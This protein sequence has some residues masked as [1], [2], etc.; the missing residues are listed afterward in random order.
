MFYLGKFSELSVKALDPQSEILL[1]KSPPAAL[2]AAV[3]FFFIL[4]L[5][6]KLKRL[7][8]ESPH[9]IWCKGFLGAERE[10]FEP[11]EV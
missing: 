8:R 5:L 7:K 1:P 6:S 11:P 3:R 2:C 4:P 9:T 10:G